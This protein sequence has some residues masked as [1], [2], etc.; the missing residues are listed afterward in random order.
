MSLNPRA[1][2]RRGSRRLPWVL[3]CRT[4]PPGGWNTYV[5]AFHFF[6]VGL[7]QVVLT[8]ADQRRP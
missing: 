6:K 3:C 7:A 1:W 4:T 2:T 5:A 8:W